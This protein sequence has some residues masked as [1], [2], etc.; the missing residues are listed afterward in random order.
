VQNDWASDIAFATQQGFIWSASGAPAHTVAHVGM[1]ALM[2]ASVEQQ[3]GGK[4]QL[5]HGLDCF[6]LSMVR[7]HCWLAEVAYRNLAE[8]LRMHN[9]PYWLCLEERE[10]LSS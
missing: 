10:C 4:A 3:Q 6:A 2:F 8:R 5:V 9:Q 7:E 1:L